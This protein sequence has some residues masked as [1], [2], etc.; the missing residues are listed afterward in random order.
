MW[1]LLCAGPRAGADFIAFHPATVG[2]G[3]DYIVVSILKAAKTEAQKDKELV[4]GTQLVKWR[5][6]QD[7]ISGLFHYIIHPR[8]EWPRCSA[9]GPG[10]RRLRRCTFCSSCHVESWIS[11]ISL[12]P[13][14]RELPEGGPCVPSFC[15]FCVEYRICHVIGADVDLNEW[16]NLCLLSEE[17]Q[18]SL[19]LVESNLQHST[20]R[21]ELEAYFL[22][23]YE[24]KP[25]SSQG[26][27]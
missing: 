22:L 15:I 20:T 10:A 21:A 11:Q 18:P 23:M 12:S 2:R 17:S 19:K 3:R 5:G 24:M 8:T 6:S 13:L 9:F 14:V 25:P 4:Q 26:P 27:N 16:M 7:W 1:H